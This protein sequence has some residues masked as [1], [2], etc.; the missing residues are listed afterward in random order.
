MADADHTHFACRDAAL[1]DAASKV[2]IADGEQ[3]TEMREKVFEILAASGQPLSAYDVADR[4][5]GLLER[6][7][8]PNSVYRILDLFVARNLALRVES[9]N[10]FLVNVHP[11]CV[12]DCMFLICERCGKTEH[13]DD[14]RATRSVR[15]AAGRNGFVPSR[16]IIEVL[17]LCRD[18]AQSAG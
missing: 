3:W 9:R 17:G 18:C 11:G 6:R 8:A 5:S 16:P 10:A 12:H 2:L 14:D 15:E 4:L 13:M 1:V 7:I